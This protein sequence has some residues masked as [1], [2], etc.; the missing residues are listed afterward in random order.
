MNIYT[1]KITETDTEELNILSGKILECAIDV[2]KQL[3][4]GLL[5]SAYQ[6]GLAYMFT[7]HGIFFE[8]EKT[9]SVMIDNHL[10]DAGYRADFVV[11][12][13]IILELKSVE[14]LMPIH[15]AQL[16]TYMK[17]GGFKL[18]LLL[19]F[20]ETLLRNGIKRMML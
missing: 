8:R 6:H 3:D 19:N 17:L 14:R 12:G 15:Q 1:T 5:E 13:K 11:D 10:I 4:P 7:K 16:L 20:N 18:G 9:I 2:H